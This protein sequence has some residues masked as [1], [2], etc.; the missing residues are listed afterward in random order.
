MQ[1]H[2][3]LC[4]RAPVSFQS[5]QE[6]FPCP[7]PHFSFRSSL[8]WFF[9]LG[10]IDFHWVF[11]PVFYQLIRKK[12][13]QPASA[14]LSHYMRI[15]YCSKLLFFGNF[16]A[17][18]LITPSIVST[19]LDLILFLKWRVKNEWFP[20]HLIKKFPILHLLHII[21]APLATWYLFLWPMDA[22]RDCNLIVGRG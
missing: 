1:N 9:P 14:F 21:F 5:K 20:R 7:P 4:V 15:N 16:S 18:I 11:P 22:I 13:S 3:T 17:R 8:L 19:F 10:L 12:Q 2:R 6:N